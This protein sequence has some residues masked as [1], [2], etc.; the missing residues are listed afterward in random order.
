MIKKF[1]SIS[2]LYSF[3]IDFLNMYEYIFI[4][5]IAV[6]KHYNIE[7]RMYYSIYLDNNYRVEVSLFQVERNEEPAMKGAIEY[8]AANK[9]SQDGNRITFSH[10]I[11]KLIFCEKIDNN[12]IFFRI[13][14]KR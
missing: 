12:N 2:F 1:Q 10:V 8:R 7:I 6:Q 3:G 14:T 4:K 9:K 13:D 5:L 11:R